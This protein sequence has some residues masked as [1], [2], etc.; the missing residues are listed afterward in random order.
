MSDINSDEKM[1]TS[2]EVQNDNDVFQ[3][4]F[5][6]SGSCNGSI[7]E[8][9]DNVNGTEECEYDVPTVIDVLEGGEGSDEMKSAKRAGNKVNNKMI[10]LLSSVFLVACVV[11]IGL[12]INFKTTLIVGQQVCSAEGVS[13]D[14]YYEFRVFEDGETRDS[15]KSELETVIRTDKTLV[16]WEEDKKSITS[17]LKSENQFTADVLSIYTYTEDIGDNSFS[18]LRDGF[19][20]LTFSSDFNRVLGDKAGEF[21]RYTAMIMSDDSYYLSV[22]GEEISDIKQSLRNIAGTKPTVTVYIRKINPT[23]YDPA[24]CSTTSGRLTDTL[25]SSCMNIL[26]ED[27][28]YMYI[29]ESNSVYGDLTITTISVV[30]SESSQPLG[31]YT[32]FSG[33]YDNFVASFS[34][35]PDGKCSDNTANIIVPIVVDLKAAKEY[36]DEFA[37]FLSKVF[38]PVVADDALDELYNFF[39][40]EEKISGNQ[41]DESGEEGQQ[42]EGEVHN[43]EQESG[44]EDEEVVNGDNNDTGNSQTDDSNGAGEETVDEYDEYESLSYVLLFDELHS[45]VES[46]CDIR[47]NWGL[48]VMLD[49]IIDS[50]SM[51]GSTYT[52]YRYLITDFDRLFAEADQNSKASAREDIS[53]NVN[54]LEEFRDAV[55]YSGDVEYVESSV[56]EYTEE[57][58]LQLTESYSAYERLWYDDDSCIGQIFYVSDIKYSVPMSLP[59]DSLTISEDTELMNFTIQVAT[60]DKGNRVTG[61]NID[62]NSIVEKV[63]P[64]VSISNISETPNYPFMTG[65]AESN[66]NKEDYD[67]EDNYELAIAR[68]LYQNYPNYYKNPDDVQATTQTYTASGYS[69]NDTGIWGS[70]KQGAG[71]IWNWATTDSNS[72]WIGGSW[73]NSLGNSLETIWSDMGRGRYGGIPSVIVNGT[74]WIADT[75][76]DAWDTAKDTASDVWNDVSDWWG[77]LWR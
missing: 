46:Q 9:A 44:S 25:I 69:Q 56:H 47:E 71:E 77:S 58:L 68:W 62:F 55:R 21:A 20:N 24:E 4:F 29:A 51:V 1:N 16:A 76:Q 50:V 13:K 10:A 41:E 59:E 19:N 8:V 53:A 52:D 6:D 17:M 72:A 48:N 27:S 2:G 23:E 75:A 61:L 38:K 28:E 11:G 49:S 43:Q 45:I 54:I 60:T 31:V 57:D 12:F 67:S 42:T 65:L 35:D 40:N 32:S 39:Y 73:H 14:D 26:G 7:A 70:I 15:Y 37:N 22:S 3:E 5:C 34:I 66:I 64:D 63:L 74:E 30:N 33:D 36:V 18:S